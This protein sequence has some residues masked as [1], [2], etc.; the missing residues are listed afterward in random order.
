M[1]PNFT[2]KA[3]L[4]GLVFLFLNI[5]LV[6]SQEIN[7]S[8]SVNYQKVQSTDVSVFLNLENGI[9][10]FINN[11]RWTNDA[12]KVEER[13]EC[14]FLIILETR[15][16]NSFTG[17]I[18][19]N[20]SRP[21]FGTNYKTAMFNI[22]D[23]NLAFSYTDQQALNFSVGE[24]QSEL[25]SVLAYYVYVML[26]I[27]YDSFS[28]EGGKDYY[29]KAFDIVSLAQTSSA[30]TGWAIS[31]SKNRY[32]LIE[33]LTNSVFAPF[34]T[35][36]YKYHR[37]GL[38]LMKDKKEEG[39]KNISDALINLEQVHKVKPSS[40][41]FQVFFIAKYNEIVS[42]FSSASPEDKTK[43]STLMI[44]LDPGNTKFYNKI[45]TGGK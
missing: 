20:A 39:L 27:D 9:K 25:T 35:C 5:G 28:P 40:Y 15:T 23:N 10:E 30:S 3:I 8:V 17:S 45:L 37:L 43:I 29:Q 38:D 31:E 36:L 19:I 26:G 13:I 24:F 6:K 14:K 12:F 42:M 22:N 34:R 21:V 1:V 32:W 16:D 2:N 41:L 44:K 18:Q 7:C 4:V 33:N 11:R